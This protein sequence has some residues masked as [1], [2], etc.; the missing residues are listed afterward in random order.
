M[1]QEEA[2][3]AEKK[4]LCRLI[5]HRDEQKKKEKPGKKK[6]GNYFSGKVRGKKNRREASCLNKELQRKS[7]HRRAQNYNREKREGDEVKVT[8][9][10]SD[11]EKT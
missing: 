11:E 5:P 9:K 1:I 7:K 8:E 6:S 10:M 3:T 2:D 4:D